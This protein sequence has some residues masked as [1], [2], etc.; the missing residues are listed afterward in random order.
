ME[1][2]EENYRANRR[3]QGRQAGQGRGLTLFDD[4]KEVLSLRHTT[5]NLI[6]EQK[7]NKKD[8]KFG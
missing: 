7:E 6:M 4:N 3:I 8:F 2:E 5:K 1:G